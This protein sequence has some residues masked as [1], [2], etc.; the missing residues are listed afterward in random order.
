MN[1][2]MT[3]VVEE[4]KS[5][6]EVTIEPTPRTRA[7]PPQPGDD[8]DVQP[9]DDTSPPAEGRPG[10]TQGAPQDGEPTLQQE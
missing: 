1:R 8:T 2:G 10:G 3:G 6:H 5:G 7:Q 9:G 4:K